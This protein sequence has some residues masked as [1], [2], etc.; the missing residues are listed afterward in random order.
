MFPRGLSS[1]VV[2]ND[3]SNMTPDISL[4]PLHTTALLS[5]AIPWWNNTPS[6]LN[7][8]DGRNFRNIVDSRKKSDV[9][10]KFSHE[11]KKYSPIKWKNIFLEMAS[12]NFFR[13]TQHWLKLFLL[14]RSSFFNEAHHNIE[15]ILPTVKIEKIWAD[16]CNQR[17]NQQDCNAAF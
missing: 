13:M 15:N 1:T 11:N 16:F 12:L 9:T 7:H 10:S 8:L 2:D 3:A 5:G 14:M 17:G 4:L 6:R